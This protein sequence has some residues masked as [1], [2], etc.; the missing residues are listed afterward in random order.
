MAVAKCGKPVHKDVE[1]AVDDASGREQIFHTYEAAAAQ[2]LAVAISTG[3]SSL[4]VLIYSA[5]GAKAY[6][7]DD[8]VE[9]YE[10]DPDASVFERFEISVNNVGRVP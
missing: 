1:F 5:E 8:A 4:D 6:G 10:D 9:Q 3:E 7:G 2:A